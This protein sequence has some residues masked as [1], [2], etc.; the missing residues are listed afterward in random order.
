[1]DAPNYFR[2]YERRYRER[3]PAWFQDEV[4]D[5]PIQQEIKEI[6]E[7][8]TAF[9]ELLGEALRKKGG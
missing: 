4:G 6:R 8:L 7:R 5:D 1:M 9:E 2:A 3:H